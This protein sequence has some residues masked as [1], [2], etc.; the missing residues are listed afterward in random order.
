MW[1]KFLFLFLYTFLAT[2][3]ALHFT[4]VS[5]SL[6]GRVSDVA[7]RLASLFVIYLEFAQKSKNN[8]S[9]MDESSEPE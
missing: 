8:K 9:S 6:L 3:V 2:L 7:P 5:E 1:D 4:P